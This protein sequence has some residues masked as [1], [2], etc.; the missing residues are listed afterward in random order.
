MRTASTI[1]TPLSPD[2]LDPQPV[3]NLQPGSLRRVETTVRFVR[4]FVPQGRA[5][6]VA[7]TNHFACMVALGT[8]GV[9]WSHTGYRGEEVDHLIYR[10]RDTGEA[11]FSYKPVRYFIEPD[12]P[13]PP[14]GPYDAITSFE[15]VEHLGFNPGHLFAALGRALKLGGVLILSTPNVGGLTPQYHLAR[16][17]APYQTPFFPRDPWLHTREYGVY[18][19]RLLLQWAGYEPLRVETHDVYTTD[20]RGPR[21]WVRRACLAL[22]G[23]LTFDPAA[24]R[25]A[26][27]YL[28][29]TQFWAA[30][31]VREPG[32]PKALPPA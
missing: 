16:G 14:G 2:L 31:K 12:S 11:V 23:S 15:L 32:D 26:L 29:S 24:V 30:R 21:A 7:S 3:A 25:H 6:D 5:L 17:A 20:I 8:P 28:G 13:P 10:R 1:P 18:E 27:S 22:A 9:E 19:I 4:R